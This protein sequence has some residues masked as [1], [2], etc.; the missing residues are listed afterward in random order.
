MIRSNKIQPKPN[1]AEASL[2]LETVVSSSLS[3][4]PRTTGAAHSVNKIVKLKSF[5]WND[6]DQFL[7]KKGGEFCARLTPPPADHL[8]QH[9][10]GCDRRHCPMDSPDLA[11][12][13]SK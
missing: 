13:G 2:R 10:V 1:K 4:V 11:R 9:F 3:A 8:R 6:S 12:G 5:R 7:K